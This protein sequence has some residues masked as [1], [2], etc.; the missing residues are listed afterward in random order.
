[1]HSQFRYRIFR[2][3]LSLAPATSFSLHR[4]DS[5]LKPQKNQQRTP[6]EMNTKI[7]LHLS[8]QNIRNLIFTS[9]HFL[10]DPSL[11][12]GPKSFKVANNGKYITEKE[13]SLNIVAAVPLYSPRIPCC[14]SRR[15]VSSVAEVFTTVFPAEKYYENVLGLNWSYQKLS[16][17]KSSFY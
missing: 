7:Q 5:R 6:R 14:L 15:M 4:T 8:K 17:F 3:R 16:G 10:P 11:L 9:L 13:T 12:L 1:M 2:L